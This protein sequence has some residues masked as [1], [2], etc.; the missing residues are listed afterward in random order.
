M[1]SHESAPILSSSNYHQ[2]SLDMQQYLNHHGVGLIVSEDW[3]EPAIADA[4]APTSEERRELMLYK[5]GRSKAAGLIYGAIPADLHVHLDGVDANDALGMW[6]KLKKTFVK[7]NSTSRF[8]TLDQLLRVQLGPEEGLTEYAGRTHRLRDQFKQLLPDG[9]KAEQL[10]DDLEINSLLHGLP[11]SSTH[12]TLAETLW[13]QADLTRD[14]V[15]N[16]FAAHERKL[17]SDAIKAEGAMAAS[18]TTRCFRCDQL[19]HMD[20]S[21]PFK[22][23]FKK[24][25]EQKQQK[26]GGG[27]GG[28]RR[29]FKKKAN[30]EEAAKASTPYIIPSSDSHWNTNTGSSSHTTPHRKWFNT[31]ETSSVISPRNN[32]P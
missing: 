13:L 24:L 4:K 31:L 22:E 3:L 23:E 9:Y 1:S 16:K 2:W 26:Q 7:Q 17:S 20:D 25:V 29:K 21:C 19:G 15:L 14:D 10:L 18:A 12:A 11:S 6:K 32:H 28:A 8:H 5:Q 30:Q 27:S